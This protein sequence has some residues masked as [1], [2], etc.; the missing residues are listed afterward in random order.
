V[1]LSP[2]SVWAMLTVLSE[3][4]NGLTFAELAR[5]LRHPK[6]RSILS[7]AFRSFSEAFTVKTETVELETTNA[8]FTDRSSP[9][10]RS[11]I[12]LVTQSYETQITPVNFRDPSTANMI[13]NQIRQA[14]RGKISS[15]VKPGNVQTV[16]F[17]DK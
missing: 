13:N 11:Y 7:K 8:I 1:V 16:Q 5:A 12:D 10:A 14:T 4:A 6:D 3:G 2:F 17:W 9:I 15:I